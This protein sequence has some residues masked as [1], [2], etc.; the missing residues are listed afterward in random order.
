VN[1]ACWYHIWADG[2]WREPLS[3]HL[4]TLRD[5]DF[6]SC[7]RVGLVGSP[8][9]R[10][11]V[12]EE[13]DGA[14]IAAEA[15]EGFEQV[16]LHALRRYAQT[17][18]GAVLYAHTKGASN[19]GDIGSNAMWR[20]AM[21]L[22]VVDNWRSNLEAMGEFDAL[23]C[24]WLTPETYPGTIRSPFFAGNFWMA[25]CGY[26]RTLPVCAEGDRMD[27]ELW[28]GLNNPRVLDVLPGWPGESLWQ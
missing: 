8:R 9:N 24:H 26:L 5:S 19:K 7:P 28:V 2:E 1:L 14:L 25:R 18:D 27:A 21:C 6:A 16:T 13:L 3:E 10:Q 4:Q 23:G 22:R 12:R 11:D 20:R 15:D 17:H